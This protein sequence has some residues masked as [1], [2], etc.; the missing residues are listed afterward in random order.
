MV[1]SGFKNFH[2]KQQKDIKIAITN[3]E[4]N[5]KVLG[6]GAKSII[7]FHGFGQD[8]NSFLPLASKNPEYTIYSIDLPFHGRTIIHDPSICIAH[9]EVIELAG[10]LIELFS[11]EKFS[12]IGFSIG[13]K[14]IFPVIE[15]FSS[16]I[17]N[18]WLLAPDGIKP[19]FWYRVATETY[20][21]R[22]IFRVLLK[23]YEII[24]RLGYGLRSMHLID[25]GTLSFILK[26]TNSREKRDRVCYIWISLRKLELNLDKVSEMLNESDISVFF[27]L[28]ENDKIIPKSNIEP[29]V[30]RTKNSKTITL[31]CAHQNIIECFADWS[32]GKSS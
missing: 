8:G 18:V 31:S 6:D 20:L 24:K 13:G 2:L 30:N 12:L 5:C 25:K 9:R 17:E 16:Q 7:A 10:K 28:G 23:N 19:L 22:Q 27:V 1:N 4:F 29:L 15:K 21:T 26:A 32:S 11:L 3:A 14:L